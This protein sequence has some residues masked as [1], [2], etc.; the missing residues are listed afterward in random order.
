MLFEVIW[1]GCSLFGDLKGRDNEVNDDEDTDEED[2]EDVDEE[3][4][5]EQ[6]DEQSIDKLL[7]VSVM[8]ESVLLSPNCFICLYFG[9]I[10][11]RVCHYSF[12]WV[13][14]ERK[15]KTKKWTS[16]EEANGVVVVA[17]D[18]MIIWHWS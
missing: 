7:G 3:H 16:M 8:P 18:C 4:D 12:K 15:K 10:I 9:W 13:K 11:G 1:F 5:D 17:A 14:I 6:D 2:S